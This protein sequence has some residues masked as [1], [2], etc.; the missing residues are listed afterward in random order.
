MHGFTFQSW[1]KSW[2]ISYLVHGFTYQWY[3]ARCTFQSNNIFI[4]YESCAKHI[5]YSRFKL[6]KCSGKNKWIGK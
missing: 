6:L 5:L 3:A 4:E 2:V 1:S